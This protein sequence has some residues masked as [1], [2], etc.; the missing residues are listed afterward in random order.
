M[1][2]AVHDARRSQRADVKIN[3]LSIQLSDRGVSP[4]DGGR[5]LPVWATAEVDCPALPTL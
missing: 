5:A 1:W 3:V 4:D 2:K